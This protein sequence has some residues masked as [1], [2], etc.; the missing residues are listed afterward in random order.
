MNDSQYLRE[1]KKIWL[2]LLVLIAG[3]GLVFLG[4]WYEMYNAPIDQ[5]YQDGQLQEWDCSFPDQPCRHNLESW[6]ERAPIR[7][8]NKV[9][10][11]LWRE[12]EN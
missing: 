4:V 6:I 2:F 1:T 5:S 8:H 9:E 12:Y 3:L 11:N 7:F 10:T